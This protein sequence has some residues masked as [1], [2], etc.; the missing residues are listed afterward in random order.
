MIAVAMIRNAI[1]FCL[2]VIGGLALLGQFG[3]AMF[4]GM[5]ADVAEPAAPAQAESP[6]AVPAG[7]SGTQLLADGSGHFRATAMVN[8]QMIAMIVDTGASTVVLTEADARRVGLSLGAGDFTGSATTA[9]GTV[10]VAPIQLDRVSV[11]G[12]ERRR[13]PAVVAQG[14]AL[15]ASLLG[16]SYLSQLGEVRIANGQMT[17]TN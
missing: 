3:G 13:V 6:V 11:G 9:G 10:R 12:I 7:P 14:P 15:P 4:D 5:A 16:Q 2:L 8:G 1:F 17:L